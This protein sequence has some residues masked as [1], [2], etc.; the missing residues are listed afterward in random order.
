M[1]TL[2]LAII[3]IAASACQALTITVDPNS[4]V[5]NKGLVTVGLKLTIT[6]NEYAAMQYKGLKFAD[7]FERTRIARVYERL[8]EQ[9]TLALARRK[10]IAELKAME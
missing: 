1:K 9:V 4:I 8:V 3:L 2:L 10:T 6:A 7:V 5:E